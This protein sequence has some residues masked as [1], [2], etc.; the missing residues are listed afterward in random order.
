MV[1]FRTVTDIP[2]ES[3]LKNR[4]KNGWNLYGLFLANEREADRG[5]TRS[6]PHEP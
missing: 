3:T 4:P 5:P 2:K 1:L 6:P